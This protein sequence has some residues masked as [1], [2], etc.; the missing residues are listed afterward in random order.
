MNQRIKAVDH[1]I[2]NCAF[3]THSD[4][5]TVV[6]DLHTLE[7]A[8]LFGE[9]LKE[10][11][12]PNINLVEEKYREMH[13]IEPSN[14][15][16]EI[17]KQSNLIFGLTSSSMAHTKARLTAC[18]SGARYLSMP[19][20][21]WNLLESSAIMTNYEDRS[22]IVKKIADLFTNG[23]K[24]KI[25]SELGTD[26]TMQINDRIGNYCP[27]FVKVRGD[28][29]SPPD[30]E[31]NVSPI[32]DK[33]DGLLIIDGSIPCPEIGL[34]DSPVKLK[35]SKGKVVDIFGEKK[36]II[37]ILKNIFEKVGSD[38]AYV[39]AECGIGLNELAKLTGVMLT[40]EGANGHI[41]IG[42]GSNSTVGGKNSVNF[43]LDFVM[44]SASLKI[45]DLLV[46]D[47]G[48]IVV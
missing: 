25:T 29:G 19:E 47:K 30:I 37:S 5:I 21:S 9:R 43:H 32:E 16:A 23:K 45:D 20:Y 46:V 41:H 1:I 15:T 6:Y 24:I 10:L 36:E 26:L 4:R 44:T 14:E 39:I 31:A 28:L 38:K 3:A 22:P 42:I 40:D 8:K 12:F 2:N 7:I 33:T 34:L 11:N 48:V 35:V 18:N 17:M 13:G 27:G